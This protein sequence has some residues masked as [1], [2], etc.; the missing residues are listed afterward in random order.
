MSWLV[1]IVVTDGQILV[2][3]LQ[4]QLG[5]RGTSALDVIWPDSPTAA[6]S[7]WCCSTC[8][9]DLVAPGWFGGHPAHASVPVPL[10]VAFPASPGD[11]PES[12]QFAVTSLHGGHTIA[13]ATSV[14]VARRTLI[15]SGWMLAVR[16]AGAARP[17]ESCAMLNPCR[18]QP[19]AG[20]AGT[21]S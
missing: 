4:V 11:H 3:A 19:E 9:A 15:P 16:R 21:G 6:G 10:L 14:P 18:R 17:P 7:R 20:V 8:K 13:A 2:I 1:V 12:V 5:R